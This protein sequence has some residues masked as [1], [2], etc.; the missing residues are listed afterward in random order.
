MT[1][2][3]VPAVI[4]APTAISFR[5]PSWAISPPTSGAASSVTIPVAPS[6]M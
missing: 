4:Q 2:N 1:A 3:Q 5:W 6:V